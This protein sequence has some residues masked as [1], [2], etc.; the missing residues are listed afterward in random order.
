MNC[1]TAAQCNKRSCSSMSVYL[2]VNARCEVSS[3][4]ENT[5]SHRSEFHIPRN[6][7]SAT[8]RAGQQNHSEY[9]CRCFHWDLHR[10]K[11]LVLFQKQLIMP[12]ASVT[13]RKVS[14]LLKSVCQL[15]LLYADVL[16]NCLV[17]VC[18]WFVLSWLSLKTPGWLSSIDCFQEK[19]ALGRHK[20]VGKLYLLF[21]FLQAGIN[22]EI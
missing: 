3:T 16:L 14:K 13:E 19:P 1:S 11:S 6:C 4:Q 15:K 18:S 17:V 21:Y 22:T 8:Y 2:V 12:H 10:G 7:Q 5:N 9:F 20:E